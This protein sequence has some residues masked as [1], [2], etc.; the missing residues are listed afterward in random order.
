M[1]KRHCTMVCLIIIIFV[2]L[3]LSE[4]VVKTTNLLF[5]TESGTL[6][7]ESP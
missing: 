6:V 3:P 4:L 7:A 1:V 5:V 2:L